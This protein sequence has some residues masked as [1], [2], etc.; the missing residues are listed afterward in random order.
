M[1]D[2]GRLRCA[3]FAARPRGQ[4]LIEAYSPKEARY[5][6]WKAASSVPLAGRPLW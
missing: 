1:D 4:R 5:L 3:V 6:R 2:S